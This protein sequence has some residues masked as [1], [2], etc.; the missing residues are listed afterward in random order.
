M[1]LKYLLISKQVALVATKP[2]DVGEYQQVIEILMPIHVY[3]TAKKLFQE[4]DYLIANK[5]QNFDVS[6][7]YQKIFKTVAYY[8]TIEIHRTWLYTKS[9]SDS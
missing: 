8:A 7:I 4:A 6:E 1:I 2:D 5:E 3:W 9:Q